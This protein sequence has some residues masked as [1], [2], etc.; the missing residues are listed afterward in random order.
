VH[1]GTI[2]VAAMASGSTGS[3]LVVN[4]RSVNA[5]SSMSDQAVTLSFAGTQGQSLSLGVTSFAGT[6]AELAVSQSG[7]AQIASVSCGGSCVLALP[8]LP[9]TG[10]YTITLT[11]QSAATIAASVTLSSVVTGTVAAQSPYG[12]ALTRFGQ[13]ARLTFGATTGQSYGLNFAQ[14]IASG[15]ASGATWKFRVLRPN[16]DELPVALDFPFSTS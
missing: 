11:P 2:S 4:G 14:A 15:T 3:S 13:I 8:S 5:A 7:G 10:T 12:G 1:E 16:G 6:I 9:T